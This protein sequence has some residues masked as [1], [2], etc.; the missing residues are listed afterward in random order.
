[1]DTVNHINNLDVKVRWP[2]QFECTK[3]VSNGRGLSSVVGSL[4]S[5]IVV[6]MYGLRASVPPV[7]YFCTAQ[8]LMK[9]LPWPTSKSKIV[10]TLHLSSFSIPCNSYDAGLVVGS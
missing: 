5:I 8:E 3:T 10:P 6:V 2:S 1:M 4:S 9:M 7:L